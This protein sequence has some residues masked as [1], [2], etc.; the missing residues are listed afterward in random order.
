MNGEI[1]CDILDKYV[2]PFSNEVF[3][4]DMK[5]HQDNASTHIGDPAKTYVEQNL[6]WVNIF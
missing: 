3:E 1:Y 5:F 2:K 4:G 6:N